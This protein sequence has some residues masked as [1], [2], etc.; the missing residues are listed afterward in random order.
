MIGTEWIDE[1]AYFGPPP[2][3]LQAALCSGAK[4]SDDDPSCKKLHRW[5]LEHYVDELHQTWVDELLQS[6]P[7]DNPVGP[8]G[9]WEVTSMHHSHALPGSYAC[10]YGT[11]GLDN[12]YSGDDDGTNEMVE[13]FLSGRKQAAET[14]TTPAE[15]FSRNSLL[16]RVCVP[17]SGRL[18]RAADPARRTKCQRVKPD[19]GRPHMAADPRKKTRMVMKMRMKRQ[20]WRTRHKPHRVSVG[21]R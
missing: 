7:R 4:R 9:A 8:C 1:V 16:V 18:H 6:A 12:Y 17:D 19:S 3:L 20:R 21:R 14:A 10:D 2:S 15:H 11:T 5:Q 13:K